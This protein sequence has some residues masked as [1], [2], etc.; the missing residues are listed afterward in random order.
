MNLIMNLESIEAFRNDIFQ[1]CLEYRSNGD[2]YHYVK[3]L[4]LARGL[5]LILEDVQQLSM[6]NRYF[7][8]EQDKGL[9]TPEEIREWK[10]LGVGKSQFVATLLYA[11][12]VFE[13]TLRS[14]L[15]S[16]SNP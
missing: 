3:S 16:S 7:E 6:C 4:S 14:I 11:P 12:E 1:K 10:D 15:D 9:L 13:K 5:N 2:Y 8:V